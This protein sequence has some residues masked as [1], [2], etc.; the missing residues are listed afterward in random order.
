MTLS[1]L[2]NTLGDIVNPIC[3]AVLRLI[4]NSNF[5]AATASLKAKRKEHGAKRKNDHFVLHGFFHSPLDA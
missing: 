1:A 4:T 2:A 3:L 5:L